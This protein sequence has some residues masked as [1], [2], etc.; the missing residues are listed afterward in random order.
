[1]ILIVTLGFD[2]KFQIRAIMRRAPNLEK[3]IITGSFKEEK[4]KKALD[5][6]MEFFKMT[7]F[8]FELVEVDPHDFYGTVVTMSRLILSNQGK[9]FVVNLSGGMRSLILAVLSSF[10]LTNM[11]A[12]VEVETEDFKKVITFKISDLR[13]PSLS[14]DHINILDAISK[15]YNTVNSI[16]N[17]LNMPLSTVWRRLRELRSD[18]LVTE[19]NRLTEKGKL[20]LKLYT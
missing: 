13:A 3:V 16:H 10:I 2:E 8:S 1:M 6:L 20:M 18:G 14:A 11:D 12:E 7:G 5:S 19:D 15:G 4:A 9:E 17:L